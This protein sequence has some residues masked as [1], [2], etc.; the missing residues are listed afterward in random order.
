MKNAT[1]YAHQ[2]ADREPSQKTWQ[3]GG[4]THQTQTK[5]NDAAAAL[6]APGCTTSRKE[7]TAEYLMTRKNEY[8]R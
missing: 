6:W 4:E 2:R 8:Q 5:R 7:E 1:E 3:S